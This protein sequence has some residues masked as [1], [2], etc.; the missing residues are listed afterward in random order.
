MKRILFYV[1]TSITLPLFAQSPTEPIAVLGGHS[2]DVDAVSLSAQGYIATGSFDH[3]INIYKAD[4]PFTLF[5]T[6]K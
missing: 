6:L 2:N 5:K 1:L 4:S 3:K